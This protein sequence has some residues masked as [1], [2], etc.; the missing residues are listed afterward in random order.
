MSKVGAIE[1]PSSEWP[2]LLSWLVKVVTDATVAGAPK[3]AALTT[4]GYLTEE[5]R[6]VRAGF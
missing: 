3:A 2:D 1:I 5:L 4:L 6:L